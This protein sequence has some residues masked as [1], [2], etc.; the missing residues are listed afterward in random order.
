M[1]RLISR[2][3]NV[4]V[5]EIHGSHAANTKLSQERFSYRIAAGVYVEILAEADQFGA[6]LVIIGSHR[7]TMAPYLLESNAKTLVR[8]ANVRCL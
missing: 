1:Y 4:R 2:R 7:P 3:H 6:D 8:Y 5:L